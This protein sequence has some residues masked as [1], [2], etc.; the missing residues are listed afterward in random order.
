M[1]F[2]NYRGLQILYDT[3]FR[4]TIKLIFSF[5][6]NIKIASFDLL[7]NKDKYVNKQRS[8]TDRSD[9]KDGH[10][11]FKRSFAIKNV[12]QMKE[13]PAVYLANLHKQ[14]VHIYY[15]YNTSILYNLLAVANMIL[16][17]KIAKVFCITRQSTILSVAWLWLRNV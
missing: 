12:T 8:I 9:R 11:E 14:Y 10:F 1:S 17:K 4:T 16:A 6:P 3:P 7:L 2:S 15:T 5:L 13:E